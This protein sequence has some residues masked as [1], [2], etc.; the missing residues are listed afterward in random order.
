M[1]LLVPRNH[2]PITF[3]TVFLI[4]CILYYQ[5]NKSD[6]DPRDEYYER[7]FLP[8]AGYTRPEPYEANC[9][10]R[11]TG[12]SPII[13]HELVAVA[14]E[15]TPSSEKP[16]NPYVY[17]A[18]RIAFRDLYGAPF[19]KPIDNTSSSGP[20]PFYH[21]I[22]TLR[23]PYNTCLSP[24]NVNRCLNG[25]LLRA[26]SPLPDGFSMSFPSF[27]DDAKT[28]YRQALAE[29]RLGA[30]AL[31]E[32]GHV[33]PIPDYFWR[34]EAA[35]AVFLEDA[36]ITFQADGRH[37]TGLPLVDIMALRD[38]WRSALTG[39]PATIGM[40]ER[41]Y[42][43]YIDFLIDVVRDLGMVDGYDAQGNRIPVKALSDRIVTMWKKRHNG[44]EPIPYRLNM[45]TTMLRHSDHATGGALSKE[46]LAAVNVLREKQAAESPNK[47]TRGRAK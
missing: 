36:A 17:D 16:I 24:E 25:G 10:S 41:S 26:A 21:L 9:G 4:A 18:V 23:P 29:G 27:E 34:S 11:A 37:V 3:A 45:M 38:G 22:L 44:R 6:E 1:P 30:V 2:V 46:A 39:A 47:R 40:T 42:S 28:R 33:T 32:S 7:Y 12:V 14:L 20:D 43:P 15:I 35:E 13:R 31:E 19:S 5:T 8:T